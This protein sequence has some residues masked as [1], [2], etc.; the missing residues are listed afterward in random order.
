MSSPHHFLACAVDS[1]LLTHLLGVIYGSVSIPSQKGHDLLES[2]VSKLLQSVGPTA[3]VL[4][5]LRYTQSGCDSGTI[6]IAQSV[7]PNSNNVICL[8]PP[9]VDLA[10]DDSMIDL[11]KAAWKVVMGSEA[12]DDEFMKF[13]DREGAQNED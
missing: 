8:P 6:D 4:W 12:K 10:Y 11:V 9:S 13:E 3:R 1:V 7:E 5:S 2:A